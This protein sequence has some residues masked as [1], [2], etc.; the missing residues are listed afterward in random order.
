MCAF[1]RPL[2]KITNAI[3]YCAG[4]TRVVGDAAQMTNKI[5]ISKRT[6][7]GTIKD[8]GVII[9]IWMKK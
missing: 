4:T 6:Y 1:S 9:T 3:D 5:G 8:N 7:L 2:K